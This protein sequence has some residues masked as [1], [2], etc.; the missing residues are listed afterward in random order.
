MRR[1]DFVSKT[2]T[3]FLNAIPEHDD[4]AA[5]SFFLDN[6]TMA[7][8]NDITP[9]NTR[10]QQAKDWL[11]EHENETIVTAS[12]IFKLQSTTLRSSIQR[13]PQGPQGGQN[14]IL[15]P[16]QENNLNQFIRA[17]LDHSLLPTKAVLLAAITR[18][19][20]LENKGPPTDRWFQKWWKTQPLHKVTTKPIAHDRIT[21]QDKLEV[22]DWFKRYQLVLQKHDIQR[23]DIWNFDETGFRIGCP[24]GQQIY[25][26]PEVKEVGL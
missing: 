1:A 5:P 14:R 9:L 15:S 7:T 25:V 24:K 18:L 10:I 2:H 4:S 22:E 26:P 20:G 19:R 13:T 21:A 23:K 6:S 8:P 11:K 16:N 17:Y 3:N 12:R